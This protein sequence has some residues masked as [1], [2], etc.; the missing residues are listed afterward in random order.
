[1]ILTKATGEVEGSNAVFS[2]LDNVPPI[3]QAEVHLRLVDPDTLDIRLSTGRQRVA[4]RGADLLVRDGQMRI[5][6]LSLPDQNAVIHT[7]VEGTIGSAMTLLGEPRLH[8]LSEHPVNLK[9]S[10]GDVSA[11]LDLQFPLQTDLPVDDIQ[12]HADAHLKRVKLLDVAGGH[13]LEDG[14][15]DLG[16][17]KE[18]LS[19]KGRGQLA[20]IPVTLDGTMDFN[21]GAA[22]QVVQRLTV[23]GQPDA[24]QLDAA[25]LPLKHV[26]D[27]SMPMTAVVIERRN[28]DGSVLVNGDLTQ[29]MLEV[30]PL[31]WRK[32]SGVTANA[33]AT[34][35]TSHGRLT[36]I[37]RIAV[38]GVGLLLSGSAGFTDGHLRSVRVDNFQ[39]GR[40]QGHG[41]INISANDEIGIVVQ[42][43][44][45]DLSPKL[46]AKTSAAD[47]SDGS[48]ATRP[49]WT[50]NARFD[51]AILANEEIASG[52]LAR[53]TGAGDAIRLLDT[54]GATEAGAGFAIKIEPSA[55]QPAPA[56][57]SK[58]CRTLSAGPGRGSRHAR[59]PSDGRCDVR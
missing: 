28:G 24:A 6:G 43:D 52:L 40:S 29:A 27:G 48:S 16:I 41:L 55:G 39:L 49:V 3:E 1:M 15:F 10:G 19:V 51:R 8:L 30:S 37:D 50:L 21:S 58:R 54:V 59:R 53:A 31:A 4:N 2:W 12:I 25:G 46:K 9:F 11:T 35:I 23:S 7:R 57:G 45:V 56:G 26:V 13:E 34:L 36:R 42:G 32:P 47:A 38:R 33:T 18:G 44:Q 14:A 22:D 20:T 17:T 5:T